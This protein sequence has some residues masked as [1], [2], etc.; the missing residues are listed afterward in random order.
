MLVQQRPEVGS[1]IDERLVVCW[2]GRLRMV[3]SASAPKQI[4]AKA[5]V[6]AE[7]LHP[8]DVIL[9][10]ILS[11]VELQLHFKYQ[12]SNPTVRFQ[13]YWVR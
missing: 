7:I 10:T 2:N 6:N 1:S 11:L 12:R 9:T 5:A 4:S 13:K 3:N 8:T